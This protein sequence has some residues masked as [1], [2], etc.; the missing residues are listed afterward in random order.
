MWLDRSPYLPGTNGTGFGVDAKTA[1]SAQSGVHFYPGASSK[2]WEPSRRVL[3]CD[4]LRPP[5]GAMRII[6][7]LS[8]LLGL[9]TAFIPPKPLPASLSALRAPARLARLQTFQDSHVDG[10]AGEGGLG[11]LSIP[12]P[13][14]HFFSRKGWSDLLPPPSVE[15]DV[16][17][18]G[19]R[20]RVAIS[21]VSLTSP[22][23]LANPHTMPDPPTTHPH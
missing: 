12:I 10:V 3:N 13:E 14:Q 18:Q 21:R 15:L 22:Q 17:I 2:Q 11:G 20:E 6:S 19:E 9:A 7:R 4:L 1:K 8:S 23:P 5:T 16:E